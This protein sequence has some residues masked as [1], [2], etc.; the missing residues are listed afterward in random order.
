MQAMN[1]NQSVKF[2]TFEIPYYNLTQSTPL[3]C[4]CSSKLQVL[5]VSVIIMDRY[6]IGY[7]VSEFFVQTI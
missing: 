1:E 2:N 3:S 6:I 7:D 4:L 5:P